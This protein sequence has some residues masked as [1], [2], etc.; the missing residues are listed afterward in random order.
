L[1]LELH[2]LKKTQNQKN[3]THLNKNDAHK[4]SKI[5]QRSGKW[6]HP[7]KLIFCQY[8][9]CNKRKTL[10]GDFKT[11]RALGMPVNK[12]KKVHL[13]PICLEIKR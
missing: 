2:Q 7:L 13:F 6:I 5:K 10:K 12:I 11:K 8:I 4:M 1:S 9:F 3:L